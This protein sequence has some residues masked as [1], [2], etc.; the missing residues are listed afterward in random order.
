MYIDPII[1][2]S[3]DFITSLCITTPIPVPDLIKISTIR[4]LGTLEIINRDTS[5]VG[6]AQMGVTDRL[7]RGWYTA[8]T[9]EG[10]FPVL[11]VLRLW[12]HED[13]T[14]KS[15]VFLNGFPS[16]AVYDV[17]G[18]CF[19]PKERDQPRSLGWKLNIETDILKLLERTCVKRSEALQKHATPGCGG[20]SNSRNAD[21]QRIP[22]NELATFLANSQ[23]ASALKEAADV[24]KKSQNIMERVI[25]M[26]IYGLSKHQIL[27]EWETSA[28]KTYA[29]IGELRN[30]SD[31]QRAGIPIQDTITKGHELLNPKPMVL[32]RLGISPEGMIPTTKTS[33]NSVSFIRIKIPVVEEVQKMGAVEYQSSQ[34]EVGIRQVEE[35]LPHRS[36]SSLR[37]MSIARTQASVKKKKK[38]NLDDMLGSFM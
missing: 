4:N 14:T 31:F 24:P 3:F 30:D 9:E 6:Y 19:N 23:S 13:L 11:R 16:L 29:R 18:C 26:D 7:I 20:E 32:L 38:R 33:I 15:L 1:S 21:I 27:D 34:R 5:S 17:R 35:R 10:A 12:N 36:Q 22:R 28:Y 37:A 2:N 8:A 25:T